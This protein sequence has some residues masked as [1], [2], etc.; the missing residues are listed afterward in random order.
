M[1]WNCVLG[2]FADAATNDDQYALIKKL[3]LFLVGFLG[4]VE[5][6]ESMWDERKL[7]SISSLF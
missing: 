6:S 1:W 4:L 5:P 2:A 3:L 7:P